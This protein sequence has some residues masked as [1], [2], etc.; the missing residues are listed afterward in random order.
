MPWEMQLILTLSLIVQAWKHA[1]GR[2]EEGEGVVGAG[3]H[4]PPEANV[5][6]SGSSEK[7]VQQ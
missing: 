3:R 1:G 2:L 4:R 5:E 6:L 7:A